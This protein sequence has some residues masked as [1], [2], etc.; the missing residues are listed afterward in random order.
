VDRAGPGGKVLLRAD[1]GPYTVTTT[2]QLR[3]GGRA[4]APVTVGG[5]DGSGAPRA[6][7]IVSDRDVAAGAVGSE[8]F[9]LMNGANHL[10][11]ET[12]VFRNVGNGAFRF[13]ADVEDIS[14]R[15]V[16]AY[17]VQRFIEDTAS[18]PNATATVT[19]LVVKNVEIRGF[20]KA[21]IRLRYDSNDIVIEDVFGDSEKQAHDNFAIGVALDGTVHGVVIRRTTMGNAYNDKGEYWNGDG[22]TTER[23]V[24]D[25]RFENTRSFGNT[26]AGY[27]LK[28]RDTVLIGAVA[29]KNKRNFRIWSDSVTIKDSTGD[30]PVKAG[31]SGSAA[32]VWLADGAKAT[33]VDSRF[34]HSGSG[35]VFELSKGAG[36]ALKGAVR[37]D[38][39]GDA[40]SRL[41]EGATIDGQARAGN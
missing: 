37:H 5:A 25:V 7:E 18:K 17:N 38:A 35:V 36:L 4:G 2:I 39:K 26:D 24:H 19:R 32:Q 27:D 8:V 15:S 31:G 33:I 9:R 30:G 41:G 20:S 10:A 3:A 1:Q 6:A 22:F 11:F 29:E 34:V 14:I 13:G 21:A 23:G 16:K 12:L 28:S 40:W